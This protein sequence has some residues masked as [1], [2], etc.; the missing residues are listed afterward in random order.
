MTTIAD[1]SNTSPSHSDTYLLPRDDSESI[2]L[3][4]Q[5]Y[6]LVRRQGWLLHPKVEEAISGLDSP[7]IAD[8]ACGTGI[9]A[10]EVAERLPRASVTG[11]D[12]SA[13]QFMPKW[14]LPANVTL[15]ILDLL[16]E[17]GPEYHGK[18]DVVHVRLLLTAGPL[19]D[20][21][22]F[23][24]TF[25]KLL[26]PGGYLQWED[27][28]YPSVQQ[29]VP[30]MQD[31][32]A[33]SGYRSTTL[34][35]DNVAEA[36]QLVHKAGWFADFPNWMQQNSTFQEAEQ[37]EIPVYLPTLKV[38]N[39]I[40]SAGFFSAVRTLLKV[41]KIDSETLLKGIEE[42]MASFKRAQAGGAL[43]AYIWVVGIAR[44]A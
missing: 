8:V 10:V 5:H 20:P 7:Q 13:G 15:N 19:T 27:I 1:G 12:I 26:K 44:A 28:P 35:W 42:D 6:A 4:L 29:V 31:G 43:M 2:R 25:S 32:G 39:D 24:K 18:F 30:S 3:S 41:V 38:E 21:R 16:G 11:L 33:T 34:R 36:V 14:T 9:W 17:V 40:A 23:T 22:N 37:F